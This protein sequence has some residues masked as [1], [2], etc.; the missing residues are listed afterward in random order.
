[1]ASDRALALHQQI[2]TFSKRKLS[3]ERLKDWTEMEKGLYLTGS[4]D[5]H[6]E[7]KI[8]ASGF[9]KVDAYLG[10]NEKAPVYVNDKAA[11]VGLK[12]SLWMPIHD[13]PPF[14]GCEWLDMCVDFI[15]FC[16]KKGWSLIVHCVAGMS[17]SAMVMIA[18]YMKDQ[19]LTVEKAVAK[20]L[21]KRPVEPDPSFVEGLYEYKDYLA[22]TKN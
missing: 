15:I 18:F 1:M 7:L 8:G 5:E 17:R 22:K 11:Q 19:N 3:Q 10:V 12:A 9:P 13:R 20:V 2:L 14:P 4:P 16:R 21:A 6:G